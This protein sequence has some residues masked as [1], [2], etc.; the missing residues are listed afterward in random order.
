MGGF[1][2]SVQFRTDDRGSILPLL[3]DIAKD[4]S[5]RFLCGPVI[6]GWVGVYPSGSGQDEAVAKTLGARWPGELFYLAVHDD[7]VLIYRYFRAGDCKDAYWSK[8]GY[9]GEEN[10]KEQEAEAGDPQRYAH[11]L[12]G[13]IAAVQRLLVRGD[14]QRPTFEYER[15]VPFGALLGMANVATSYEYLD[16]GERDGIRG[17]RQFVHVPDRSDERQVAKRARAARVA[18]RKRLKESGILLDW[19]EIRDRTAPIVVD[20][21]GRP[22]TV[23]FE[24]GYR[25]IKHPSGKGVV[26]PQQD[27][28]VIGPDDGSVPRTLLTGTKTALDARASDATFG[29]LVVV[30]PS[31]VE[32]APGQALRALLRPV[33]EARRE[34]AERHLRRVLPPSP[35]TLTQAQSLAQVAGHFTSTAGT[36]GRASFSDDGVW[37][38]CTGDGL[39]I[40][41]WSDVLSTTD[42][43][44]MP[45]RFAFDVP[46]RVLE[47]NARH[48]HVYAAVHDAGRR[49]VLFGGIDGRVRSMSLAD[50]RVD[51]VFETPEASALLKMQLLDRSTLATWVEPGFPK[52]RAKGPEPIV[53]VWDYDVLCARASD[54]VRRVEPPLEPHALVPLASDD[55]TP[56]SPIQQIVTALRASHA[57]SAKQI[58]VEPA[59]GRSWTDAATATRLVAPLLD[60][61][62]QASEPFVVP[63]LEGAVIQFFVHVESC[64]VATLLETS[65]SA[66]SLTLA[67]D[68]DDGSSFAFTNRP[69]MGLDLP[70]GRVM[71]HFAR[72]DGATL[73]KLFLAQRPPG[74]FTAFAVEELPLRFELAYAKAHAWRDERGFTDA[75][76][77]RFL[78]ERARES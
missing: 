64:V 22:M 41:A 17:W 6:D 15:L 52:T 1:Y 2:G 4:G 57:A 37:L 45:W 33:P 23:A 63:A 31:L 70:P 65:G 16:N 24:E 26:Q 36:V 44:P 67:S 32:L 48:R 58:E 54:G 78:I 53:Y 11:L 59:V 12:K 30:A 7:D 49:A 60:A 40:A 19:V 77:A 56:P 5:H 18:E 43:S 25:A 51:E 74:P 73:L 14:E 20:V 61:G 72:V 28:L 69:S 27:T 71:R 3:E 35:W 76:A 8:P 10:R 46:P 55:E 68:R 38:I 34:T 9:F 50:G 39:R 21:R 66:P 75:E 13:D 62:F 29:L 42:G 47:P